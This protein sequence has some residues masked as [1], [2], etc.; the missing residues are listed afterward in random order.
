VYHH[1]T[2]LE[3]LAVARENLGFGGY[4]ELLTTPAFQ[5]LKVHLTFQ[6]RHLPLQRYLSPQF[7]N[8]V[9]LCFGVDLLGFKVQM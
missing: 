8:I 1:V 4:K 5:E 3:A 2:F 7:P 9:L 6:R